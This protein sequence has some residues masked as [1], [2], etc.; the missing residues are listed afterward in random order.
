MYQAGTL[1]GNPIAMAGGIATLTELKKQN[2]YH[3][4]EKIGNE[5]ETILLETAHKY[6]VD[7]SVN[8]FGSMLSPFFTKAKVTNFEQAQTSDTDKFAVFFWEMIRNGVFLPPSQFEAWFLS[9][10]ISARDI[11][12]L[13][14]AVDK[15]MK[16]V[17]KM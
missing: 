3:K 4:F 10:A 15:A 8:R 9:S 1:S 12:K 16:A 17:S 11:K 7:L 5:I 6:K 14:I 2:P 13:T